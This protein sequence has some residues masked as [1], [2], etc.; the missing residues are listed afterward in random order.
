MKA[1]N[2]KDLLQQPAGH[3]VPLSSINLSEHFTHSNLAQTIA[4]PMMNVSSRTSELQQAPVGKLVEMQKP[5]EPGNEK[6]KPEA[7]EN[8]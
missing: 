4:T 2:P 5:A 8:C 7:N 3:I 6:L 1:T